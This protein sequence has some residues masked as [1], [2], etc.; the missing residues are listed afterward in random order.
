MSLIV[1]EIP[2]DCPTCD[3]CG[4]PIESGFLALICPFKAECALAPDK[5]D[6]EILQRNRWDLYDV[7][8]G[9]PGGN[10]GK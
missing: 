2:E 5:E 6:L 9:N 8:T 1:I 7:T 4:V 3:K 10:H